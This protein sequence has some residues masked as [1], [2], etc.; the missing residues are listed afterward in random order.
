MKTISITIIVGIGVALVVGSLYVFALYDMERRIALINAYQQEITTREGE[1]SSFARLATLVDETK[2]DRDRVSTYILSTDGVVAL[3]KEIESL[4]VGSGAE[5][6]IVSVTEGVIAGEE[7]GLFK[8]VVIAL[9]IDGSYGAVRH[10]V[11]LLEALPYATKISQIR[12]ESRQDG[13]K[14]VWTVP[15]VFSVL[16]DK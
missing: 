15:L 1:T 14:T 4:A 16:K 10:A 8:E 6:K 3:L 2:D 11:A 13:K 9:S 5:I 12:M 7:R